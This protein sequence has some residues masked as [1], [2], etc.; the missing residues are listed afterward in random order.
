MCVHNFW[1]VLCSELLT[2]HIIFLSIIN[3]THYTSPRGLMY[4]ASDPW[5]TMVLV[6]WKTCLIYYCFVFYWKFIVL[7]HSE[8]YRGRPNL[9]FIFQGTVL[10]TVWI[11]R[12][13]QQIKIWIIIADLKLLLIISIFSTSQIALKQLIETLKRKCIHTFSWNYHHGLHWKLSFWQLPVQPVMKISS[14]YMKTFPVQWI[15]LYYHI[16]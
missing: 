7:I 10:L 11:C 14:K 2:C 15:P 12:C 13:S 1:D 16:A 9:Q 5:S 3:K 8:P 4:G 6:Q